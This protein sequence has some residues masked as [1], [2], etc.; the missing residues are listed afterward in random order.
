M[1]LRFCQRGPIILK[2]ILN[3]KLFFLLSFLF[4]L[5]NCSRVS[6]EP[7]F[8]DVGIG[9]IENADA[10]FVLYADKTELTNYLKEMDKRLNASE[11]PEGT[12]MN[13]VGC[14]NYQSGNYSL[15]EKWL[16]QSFRESVDS[17]KNTAAYALGLIYLKQSEKDK[18]EQSHLDAAKET[19]FGRW[20]VILYYIESY[21]ESKNKEFIMS[22]IKQ[23]EEKHQKEGETKATKRFLK[24]LQVI[25]SMEE[26]CGN[27]SE[28]STCSMSDLRG[29]RTYL[30]STVH[31]L[32]SMF[33]KEPPFNNGSD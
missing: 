2:S 24:H 3:I 5:M 31:G 27:G 11:Q 32:L 23:L 19:R 4:L 18:I 9:G 1:S 17:S 30:I 22:A 20:M 7:S 25:T 10:C 6:E 16:S 33:L 15:A 8:E 14:I 28:S 29:E 21:R 13:I 26:A 12:I